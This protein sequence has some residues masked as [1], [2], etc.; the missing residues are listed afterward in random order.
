MAADCAA[1]EL[2]CGVVNCSSKGSCAWV[3]QRFGH[4]LGTGMRARFART[5]RR[6]VRAPPG[7]GTD[8]A[9]RPCCPGAGLR[10][11]NCYL[12][13]IHRVPFSEEGRC[14][15]GMGSGTPRPVEA[16]SGWALAA[17]RKCWGDVCVFVGRV[18]GAGGAKPA[19]CRPPRPPKGI[20]TYLSVSLASLDSTPQPHREFLERPAILTLLNYFHLLSSRTRA[21]L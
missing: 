1:V 18:W 6:W 5:V 10:R 20:S 14:A 8:R 2:L 12:T 17:A 4:A 3:A 21:D 13:C 9:P 7:A 16:P 15:Y 11:A 19:A